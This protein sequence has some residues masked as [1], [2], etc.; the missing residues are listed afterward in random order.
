M[1]RNSSARS[2]VLPV[3][4]GVGGVV[5]G[6]YL[7]REAIDLSYGVDSRGVLECMLQGHPLFTRLVAGSVGGAAATYCSSAF[8]QSVVAMRSLMKRFTWE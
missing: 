7:A 6:D 5:M 4:F 1:K 3:L 8:L 2:Y